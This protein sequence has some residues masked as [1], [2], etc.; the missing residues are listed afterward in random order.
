NPN[1]GQ[2]SAPVLL[3]LV[4]TLFALAT[5]SPSWVV[6]PLLVVEFTMPDYIVGFTSDFG[7]SLRLLCSVAAVV[8]TAPLI[9]TE[10]A[11]ASPPLCRVLLPAVAFLALATIGNALTSDMAYTI[12]Y[13]RYLTSGLLALLAVASAVRGRADARRTAL[14]AVALA[15]ASA[16]AAIWQHVAPDSAPY[17]GDI[18]TD[19]INY[20]SGRSV[21]PASI[22][23]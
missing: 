13:L 18:T 10:L 11:A 3:A 14:L 8:L 21:G 2:L 15:V 12:K 7:V 19:L 16:V 17:G 23:V 5:Q 20:W 22:P 1:P 9:R 6:G 4:V